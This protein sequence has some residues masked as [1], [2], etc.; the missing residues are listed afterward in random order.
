MEIEP[1]TSYILSPDDKRCHVQLLEV[2]TICIFVYNIS[3]HMN[4]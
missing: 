3:K 2:G 4:S 1:E